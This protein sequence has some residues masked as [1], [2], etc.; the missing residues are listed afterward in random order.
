VG[1]GIAIGPTSTLVPQPT[2][3]VIAVRVALP[4]KLFLLGIQCIMIPL[5][6]ASVIRGIAAGE[7]TENI[8][9]LGLVSIL[10]F[11]VTTI[12][13]VAI[14]ITAALFIKPGLYINGNVLETVISGAGAMDA[15]AKTGLPSLTEFP[16]IV[17][18]LFPKDPLATFVSGNLLQTVTGA[19]IIGVAPLAMPGE[20]RR[21]LLDLLGSIQ[22]V[23]MVIVGRVLKF[24]PI[25]VFGLLANISAHV[26]IS[27][28]LATAVYVLTVLAGL[29]VLKL[30]YLLVVSLAGRIYP[31]AFRKMPREVLLLPG[32]NCGG[33]YFRREAL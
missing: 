19:G 28:L 9:K 24:V 32:E 22:A 3:E 33:C 30:F 14:G 18:G 8:G 7:A 17:T 6:V 21:P 23:C 15:G 5:I 11:P 12:V 25:A 1:F 29:A 31:A 16:D 27:T 26:G 10:F 2:A 4:G 13:A 20:Q